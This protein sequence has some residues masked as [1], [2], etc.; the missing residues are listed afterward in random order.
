MNLKRVLE[1]LVEHQLYAKQS[2]Y[3]FATRSVDYPGHIVSEKGV[4]V[5]PTKTKTMVKWSG[6]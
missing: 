2:K 6:A 5:D 4:R 3:K 1:T